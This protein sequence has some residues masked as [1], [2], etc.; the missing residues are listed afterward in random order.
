MSATVAW[1]V[2]ALVILA[3][4]VMVVISRRVVHSAVY[5]LVSFLATAG[6]FLILGGEFVAAVQMI[7]Y[8][9]SVAVLFVFAV[10]TTRPEGSNAKRP[11]AVWTVAA[12]LVGLVILAELSA[13]LLAWRPPPVA[14]PEE[15]DITAGIGNLI[16]TEWLVPLEVFSFIILAVLMGV[17]VLRREG[18][19]RR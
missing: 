13:A 17:A 18:K 12:V 14:P 1:L 4:S 2:L 15:V 11:S 9:G 10:M 5:L 6:V 8:A 16:F 3:S 7:V 19:V